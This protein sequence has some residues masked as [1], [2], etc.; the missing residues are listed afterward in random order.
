MSS[1]TPELIITIGF[2]I[3][4]SAGLYLNYRRGKPRLRVEVMSAI[5]SVKHTRGRRDEIA[6]TELIADFMIHNTGADTSI[7]NVEIRCKPFGQPYPKEKVQPH[8]VTVKRGITTNYSHQFYISGRGVSVSPLK[9][10]FFLHHT[11]GKKKVKAK[12]I[13]QGGM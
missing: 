8:A 11:Y 10:T 13:F 5:H 6:G 7:Y 2:L 1:L 3:V 9:C 4:A 12:S